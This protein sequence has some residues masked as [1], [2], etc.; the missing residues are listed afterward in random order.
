MLRLAF[1]GL[2]V[3]TGCYSP[4][5][6]AGSPCVT[7]E[8]CPRELACIADHCGGSLSPIDAPGPADGSSDAP[9]DAPLQP[10]APIASVWS[11][12]TPVPGVNSPAVET[13]PSYTPD[14]LT[15]VFASTRAN[16]SEDLYI[17]TRA[18]TAASFTVAPI[19]GVNV[20]NRDEHSPEI[21]ADGN[22]I[23]FTSDRVTA[24]NFDVYVTT[25]GII[26][27]SPPMLVTQLSSGSDDGDVAISPD[28]L[29]AITVRNDTTFWRSTRPTTSSTWGP[30]LPIGSTVFG[31]QPASPSLT[32]AG[33]IY[34][35]AGAG[36]RDLFISRKNANGYALATPITELNTPGR[37]AAPF[38]SA[39]E[40][41]LVI[42]VNDDIY[43]STHP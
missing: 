37:D 22:T 19:P 9:P 7:N 32:A 18:T 26:T 39:D 40:K 34:L 43:E 1:V 23:Y 2:A 12:P 4:T 35:H 36:A 25:R 5:V 11:T 29:T 8:D 42:D 16:G 6:V 41:H 33:D 10:D 28:G 20:T 13:D 3:V 14:R 30:E 15:I 17:G 31:V 27:W 38:V 24:G 21:S